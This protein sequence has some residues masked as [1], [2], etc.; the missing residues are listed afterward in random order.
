MNSHSKETYP[1]LLHKLQQQ[2]KWYKTLLQ[3][4]EQETLALRNA[5]NQQLQKISQ[6]TH[7]AQTRIEQL[8]KQIKKLLNSYPDKN[9]VKRDQQISRLVKGIENL[10]TTLIKRNATNVRVV[11]DELKQLREELKHLAMVERISRGYQKLPSVDSKFLD[12]TS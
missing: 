10:L 9:I 12:C 1:Q 2:T 8:D 5:D 6:D 11:Q 7:K 4:G 3:L